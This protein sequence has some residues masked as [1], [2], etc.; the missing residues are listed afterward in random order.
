LQPEYTQGPPIPIGGPSLF[1][2]RAGGICW[3]P[4]R[5]GHAAL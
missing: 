4:A 2:L 3:L 5:A 1:Q